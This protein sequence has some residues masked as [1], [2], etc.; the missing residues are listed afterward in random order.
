MDPQFHNGPPHLRV[1]VS[2]SVS[3][4]GGPRLY[5]V[6]GHTLEDSLGDSSWLTT[7]CLVPLGNQLWTWQEAHINPK[8][9]S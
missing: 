1:V 6:F 3:Q 8:D 4:S 2:S 5:K 9:I 7:L